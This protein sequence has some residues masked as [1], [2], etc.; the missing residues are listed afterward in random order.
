MARLTDRH[1]AGLLSVRSAIAAFERISEREARAV[2]ATHAQHHLLLGL[3]GHADNNGPTVKDIAQALGVAS[4]SAVE[5]TARTVTT[6]LLQRHDDPDD[7][8]ETRL[9]LTTLR[10]RLLRQLSEAHHPRL[11]QLTA[12]GVE[13]LAD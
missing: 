8:R 3:Y 7:R 11:R 6:G 4:P 9:T 13:L 5:L 1:I 12:R 10:D 2:G